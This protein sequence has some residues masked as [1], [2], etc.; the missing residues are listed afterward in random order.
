MAWEPP[1]GADAAITT[2]AL[3]RSFGSEL[4][5]DSLTLSINPG[6]VIALLGPNG[7]GKTT[8][9][10]LLNG[11][12][13][14][15]SGSSRVLGFDPVIDGHEIRR[16]TGVMTEQSG[17]DDR[18]TARENVAVHARI[19]GIGIPDAMRR[20][21]ELLERFGLSDRA[22]Q[23]VQGFSTGQR[24]RVAL[25]R[26][27]L[28]DPELLFLDEP[29]S[30]LDPEATRDVLDLIAALARDRGRTVILCTHFLS[31]AS[32]LSGRMAVLE[33]GRLL[34]FGR[35][36]DLAAQ[37]WPGLAIEVDLGQ[38]ACDALLTDLA[39][40]GGVFGVAPSAIGA[41]VRIQNRE[42][43][44]SLVAALVRREVLVYG[45]TARPATLEDVYFAVTGGAFGDP[46]GADIERAVAAAGP[47]GG[48]GKRA[49]S[50]GGG[51][52]GPAWP[53]PGDWG[54]A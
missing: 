47:E 13:T 29:T 19:R 35:P 33:N 41:D 2:D 15:D 16:R 40:I 37:I 3:R 25:A 1:L 27:L 28:H 8:T 14:P 49:G 4:A 51:G 18:L 44:P 36:D 38:P 7:A 11:V 5:L 24:K 17:L 53:G 45:V 21:G 42:V 52:A 30:G 32:R 54:E 46:P 23:Q 50:G 39:T 6:E 31:E 22:D 43:L 34:A 26:A 20:A 10:R 48:V 9:V 12:L